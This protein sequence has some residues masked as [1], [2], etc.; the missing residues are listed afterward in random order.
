[1]KLNT[2]TDTRLTLLQDI[3]SQTPPSSPARNA[4]SFVRAAKQGTARHGKASGY[5]G[6]GLKQ[7]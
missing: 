6:Y 5:T 1:M 2:I 7:S 3:L 4:S